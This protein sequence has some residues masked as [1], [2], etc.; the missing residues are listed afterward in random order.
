MSYFS[1]DPRPDCDLQEMRALEYFRQRAAPE[2]AGPFSEELWSNFMLLVA[3]HESAIKHALV[4]LGTTHEDF[5]NMGEPSLERSQFAMRHYQ[6]AINQIVKINAPES[7]HTIDVALAS[8]LLFT[9]I[10][11]LRGHYQSA[12]SHI[13]S[14][15]KILDGERHRE[16]VFH[17]R[18]IPRDRLE[19]L[20]MHVESQVLEIGDAV[21]ETR[22]FVSQWSRYLMPDSFQSLGGAM[23]SLQMINNRMWH[24]MELLNFHSRDPAEHDEGFNAMIMERDATSSLFKQWKINFENMMADVDPLQISEVQKKEPAFLVLKIMQKT[25]EILLQVD[26]L[27]MEMDYDRFLQGFSDIVYW[28]EN[29]LQLTSTIQGSPLTSANPTPEMTQL[30]SGHQLGDSPLFEPPL[31]HAFSSQIMPK[32]NS[33]MPKTF[34]MSIGCVPSLYI[35]AARCRE[36]T[37]RHKALRLLQICNR[38]EGFWDASIAGRLAEQAILMEEANALHH[39]SALDTGSPIELRVHSAT[40]IPKEARI[41]SIDVQYGPGASGRVRYSMETPPP[42]VNGF[43]DPGHQFNDFMEW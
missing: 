21:F 14:G 40:Q 15:L 19:S 9:C 31:K 32:S 23:R 12:L 27:D 39:I 10:E 5:V 11:T 8:C 1:P 43:F 37:I 42:G 6:K 24:A 13:T 29:Y 18:C 28:S 33:V 38:R 3:T 41:K 4:A 17:T 35:C 16:N 34:S 7:P 30:S 22:A 2:L 25:L 36:P 20:F 26:V